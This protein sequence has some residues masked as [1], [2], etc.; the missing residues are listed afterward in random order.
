LY[1]L[2]KLEGDLEDFFIQSANYQ[3]MEVAGLS[4][5]NVQEAVE[6]FGE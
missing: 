6:A 4:R 2:I 1:Y 3:A 5:E